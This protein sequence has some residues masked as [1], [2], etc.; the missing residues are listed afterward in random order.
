MKNQ[1]T[2]K[3][4]AILLSF[5]VLTASACA[6][7]SVSAASAILMDGQTGRVLWSSNADGRAGIASTTKIMTGLIIAEDCDLSAEVVVSE[8]A[9]NVEGSS[10]DLRAGE[11]LT[12]EALLYGMMLQSGNDAAT[13][14]AVYHSGSV[15][16]FAMKMNERAREMGLHQTHFVNPHGLDDEAHYSTAADLAVLAACAMENPIFSKVVST[17]MISFGSRSF[18]NHN[19][20]LWQ[21][22]GAS[23]V[24]TG[25]TRAAGR[26]LVSCAERKGRRLIAVTINDRQDW[27]DHK[28][29][30][31]YGFSCY[32]ESIIADADEAL[33]VVPV[34]SGEKE[35]VQLAPIETIT[36]SLAADEQWELVCYVPDFVYAPV[37]A[38]TLAGEAAVLV[39]GW[40]IFRIPLYWRETVVEGT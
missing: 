31:D 19:R 17:K 12:V 9:V 26:I 3:I 38:G 37:V 13:A 32:S 7:P 35:Y 8:D 18:C 30:L 15:R 14:L 40:E 11:T 34:M 4:A 1:W 25:Y 2:I 20:M 21:Y 33:A 29:L 27:A 6:Q 22:D 10:I 23:G 24:K 39:D 16:A 36:C 5:A 28:M